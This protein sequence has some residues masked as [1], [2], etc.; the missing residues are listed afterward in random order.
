MYICYYIEKQFR[1]DV[2][3]VLLLHP[4][5]LQK[6]VCKIYAGETGASILSSTTYTTTF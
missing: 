3:Q 6:V 1:V 5:G 4:I 2:G